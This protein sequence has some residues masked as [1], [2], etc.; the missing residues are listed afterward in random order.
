MTNHTSQAISSYKLVAVHPDYFYVA[1][2]K[3]ESLLTSCKQWKQLVDSYVFVLDTIPETNTE[4]RI[5]LLEKIGALYM[6]RLNDQHHAADYYDQLHHIVPD[7]FETICILNRLYKNLDRDRREILERCI[8]ASK[9]DEETASFYMELASQHILQDD[10]DRAV[11]A[12]LNAVGLTPFNVELFSKAESFLNKHKQW[13]SLVSLIQD[14]LSSLKERKKEARPLPEEFS[15]SH[16]HE[17]C[18]YIQYRYLKQ[19]QNAC[20]SYFAALRAGDCSDHIIF[21]LEK[22]CASTQNWHMLAET[23]ELAASNA[24]AIKMKEAFLYRAIDIVHHR[25]KDP[26]QELRLYQLFMNTGTKKLSQLKELQTIYEKHENWTLLVDVLFDIHE[27]TLPSERKQE[28][29]LRLGMLCEEK[30]GDEVRAIDAYKKSLDNESNNSI[31]LQSLSRIYESVG[32]WHELMGIIKQQIKITTHQTAK[33]QLY[34]KYGL[35]LDSKLENISEAI[36]AYQ[37]AIKIYAECMPAVQGLRDLYRRQEDWFNVIRLLKLEETLWK[38][39]KERAFILARIGEICWEHLNEI[40]TGLTSFHQALKLDPECLLANQALFDYYFDQKNWN[41]TKFF[42]EVILGKNHINWEPTQ[43]STL[44]HHYGVALFYLNDHTNS[45][46]HITKAIEITPRALPPLESFV[47]LIKEIDDTVNGEDVCKRLHK[48][49]EGNA[50]LWIQYTRILVAQA[51]MVKN[52]GDFNKIAKICQ[53]ATEKH[54]ADVYVVLE[55]MKLYASV[56]D[57]QEVHDLTILYVNANTSLTKNEQASV[58]L[59]LADIYAEGIADPKRSSAILQQAIAFAP[60]NLFIRYRFVQDLFWLGNIQQAHIEMET[61][62]ACL[63]EQQ[64]ISSTERADYYWYYGMLFEQQGNYHMAKQQWKRVFDYQPNHARLIFVQYRDAMKNGDKE[65]AKNIVDRNIDTIDWKRY[66]LVGF[67]LLR[68]QA[69]YLLSS[70][71]KP[72]AIETLKKIEHRSPALEEYILRTR[73][74][75]T[76]DLSQAIH[77]LSRL[78][79]KNIACEIL[80]RQLND[81]VAAM[82]S[83]LRHYRLLTVMSFLRF[84]TPSDKQMLTRLSQQI[85]SPK[86]FFRMTPELRREMVFTPIAK[87]QE[88]AFLMTLMTTLRHRFTRSLSSLTI[89][90]TPMAQE[91][92]DPFCIPIVALAHAIDL[93][94][95]LYVTDAWNCAPVVFDEKRPSVVFSRQWSC[96]E[97]NA[98]LFWLGRIREMLQGGYA[99]L[100]NLSQ[101]DEVS[102]TYLLNKT[103]NQSHQGRDEIVTQFRSL[104]S[105]SVEAALDDY[106]AQSSKIPIFVWILALN[107]SAN[108]AGLMLCDDFT[109]AGA[110]LTQVCDEISCD[111]LGVEFIPGILDLTLFFLSDSYHNWQA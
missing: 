65:Y 91:V 78:L 111:E 75:A 89:N 102:F 97:R 74:I 100:L 88:G 82:K 58:L 85:K 86:Q 59:C 46:I 33:A 9:S 31:A 50:D 104:L 49:Y 43:V 60:H 6:E 11:S 56:R 72:E 108:R 76:T 36:K 54:K 10:I 37:I 39:K 81:Y 109:V 55:F 53:Q 40:N 80:Y 25:I 20:Q 41:R 42:G 110:C 87:S 66:P 12:Y 90:I 17:K 73:L 4:H 38:D 106:I 94:A 47:M 32:Q 105:N 62:I 22:T 5:F 63:E 95:D 52:K 84:A 99:F 61:L 14:I 34:C 45:L 2:S 48:D 13:I 7:N 27:Q 16:L 83:P 28:D 26:E 21:S 1:T 30:L 24:S 98:L 3:I 77:D 68:N 67:T 101:Q 93:N 70:G 19:T 107:E 29:I 18:A 51:S 71:L 15:I 23:Y 79:E 69:Q 103:L 57:Y 35:V 92:N 64:D 96:V 8:E 44:H